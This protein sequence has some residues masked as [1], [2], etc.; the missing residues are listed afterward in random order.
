[1]T[2]LS[3][4]PFPQIHPEG[5]NIFLKSK[6]TFEMLYAEVDYVTGIGSFY[7]RW[8]ALHMA[9]YNASTSAYA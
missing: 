4:L 8:K 6:M 9:Y 3:I 7:R 5:C 2:V 1:V